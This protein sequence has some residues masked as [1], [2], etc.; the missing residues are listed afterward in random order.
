MLKR[1]SLVIKICYNVNIL[2]Q[3]T[4]LVVKPVMAD[5]FV[6]LFHLDD[7]VGLRQPDNS[8]L[9]LFQNVGLWITMSVV[10]FIVALLVV[11]LCSV[12]RYQRRRLLCFIIFFCDYVL[13]WN[14]S[15]MRQ[16]PPTHT[17]QIFE[18][19]H[20]KTYN[21]TCAI[22]EDSDQP[23]HPRSLIR[24]FADRMCLLQPLLQSDGRDIAILCGCTS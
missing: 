1:K 7:G 8:F 14:V 4:C 15:L 22:S 12:F 18:P 24:V 16:R 23:A 20:D 10:W 17:D 6:P 2:Q 13:H 3:N 9:S 21:K 5:K 11:L 19:A